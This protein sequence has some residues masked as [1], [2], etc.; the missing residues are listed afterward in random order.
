[1]VPPPP[2]LHLRVVLIF[3]YFVDPS[4]DMHFN[5]LNTSLRLSIDDMARPSLPCQALSN[6]I[7]S[8]KSRQNS[9]A[10]LCSASQRN[11][12][13]WDSF[14]TANTYKEELNMFRVVSLLTNI[15]WGQITQIY[16]KHWAI[17]IGY[18]QCFNSYLFILLVLYLGTSLLKTR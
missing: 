12:V 2:S 11:Y 1:M 8:S 18:C 13:I 5:H 9:L 14:S 15:Q 16:L 17:L 4:H 7:Y 3:L 6:L 10:S